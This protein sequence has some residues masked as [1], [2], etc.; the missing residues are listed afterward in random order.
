MQEQIDLEDLRNELFCV[1]E[2][3]QI[4]HNQA[5]P[6]AMV[7]ILDKHK[8]ILAAGILRYREELLNILDGTIKE[9]NI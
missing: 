3:I 9:D 5:N 8:G 7:I 6:K 4:R 2:R 1:L